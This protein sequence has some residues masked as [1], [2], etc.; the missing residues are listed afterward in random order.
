MA[1]N[2]NY[3]E[4]LQVSPQASAQEINQ[5][6]R[7]LVNRYTFTRP[8]E[9][10]TVA[11]MMQRLEAANAVLSDPEKRAA[12]DQANGFAARGGDAP[13]LEMP[14]A[15]LVPIRETA[16]LRPLETK[17]LEPVSATPV[18]DD[19]YSLK[20]QRVSW[21]EA[22]LA[23]FSRRCGAWLLDYI[24]TL[25]IPAV[26]L[27]LAVFVKRRMPE[28]NFAGA[29]VLIGYLAAATVLLFN[30]FYFCVQYGQSFG[31]RFMGLRIVRTDGQPLGYQTALLRHLVGYPLSFL[32]LGLGL[33]WM[34][35]DKRQQCWHDK[36]AKTAVIKE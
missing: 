14:T 25:F 29:L 16:P 36:L 15:D 33:L 13:S 7:R 8:A 23:G 4:L 12:Y 19:Q 17:Q 21:E 32:A 6:Y 31:K 11:K 20:P 3:Y 24:L 35:W 34:F 26:M 22:E 18:A 5:A 2:E 28:S 1:D 30:L 27:V 10:A 9:E